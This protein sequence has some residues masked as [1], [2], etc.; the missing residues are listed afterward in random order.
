MREQVDLGGK[1][2][3]ILTILAKLKVNF[4]ILVQSIWEKETHKMKKVVT[5]NSFDAPIEIH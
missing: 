5:R 1:I 2:P 3:K 4:D